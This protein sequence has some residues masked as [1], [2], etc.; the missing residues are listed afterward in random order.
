MSK[1][2]LGTVQ[3]GLDYGISSS[4]GKV[5]KDDAKNIISFAKENKINLFDTAPAYGTSEK[6]LGESDISNVKIITKTRNFDAARISNEDIESIDIDF[7]NSLKDL[8]IE[9][10]YGLLFHNADD[11]LKP[12]GEEL[13]KAIKKLKKQKKIHKI[14]ISVYEEKQLEKILS[15][16]DIDIVQVP[17]SIIDR[18]LMDSGMIDTLYNLS[19]IH[20]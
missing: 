19:L 1:I 8:K 7:Y 10:V 14:G 5:T 17:F 4:I 3:F 6:V 9:R 15:L 20:I 16:Y 2:G 13:Y 18:R 12:G 11:L